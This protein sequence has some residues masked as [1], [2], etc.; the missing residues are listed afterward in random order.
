MEFI[1]GECNCFIRDIDRFKKEIKYCPLHAAA[2]EMY[3][4]LKEINTFSQPWGEHHS[5]FV[6]NISRKALNKAEGE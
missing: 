3:E 6:H 2:P 4:A 1:K 5:K